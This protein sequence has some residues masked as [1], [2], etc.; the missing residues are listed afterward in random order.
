VA[1]PTRIGGRARTIDGA[2]IVWSR[3]DGARGTRWR[4]ALERDG[5]MTRAV[6]VEVSSD[7]SV[8]RLEVTTVAGLLTLHPGADGSRLHG[9]VVTPNGVRH[10]AFPWGPGHGILLLGSPALAAVT[11]SRLASEIS[12]GQTIE[13]TML[14]IDDALE[15]RLMPWRIQRA[16]DSVWEV[17]QPETRQVRRLTLDP[18]GYPVLAD[19]ELWPLEV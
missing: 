16:G 9:N 1:P 17:H 12:V 10:L 11:L 4:E 8:S 6:L 2:A 18:T 19:A 15:P 14:V 13:M 5:V 3:A 7:G